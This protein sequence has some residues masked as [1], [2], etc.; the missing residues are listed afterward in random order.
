MYLMV[1]PYSLG[2]LIDWKLDTLYN[3]LLPVVWE[4]PYSLGKLIDWKHPNLNGLK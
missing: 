4:S 1:S 3:F 2:K